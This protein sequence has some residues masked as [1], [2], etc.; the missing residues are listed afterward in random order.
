MFHNHRYIV[1]G[2]VTICGI[3]LFTLISGCRKQAS[4]IPFEYGDVAVADTVLKNK[5]KGLLNIS[6][7]PGDTGVDIASG[8]V[9]SANTL[10]EVTAFKISKIVLRIRSEILAG[11]ITSSDTLVTFTPRFTLDRSSSYT[12]EIAAFV[13]TQGDKELPPVGRAVNEKYTFTTTTANPSYIMSRQSTQVTDFARDGSEL[14]QVGDH[15]YLYGGWTGEGS[16]NDV[17][18]SNGDLSVWDR[19]PDAPWAGRHT[20]GVAKIA[21]GI[22]VFGGDYN[23]SNFDV[24]KTTNGIA[25]EPVATNLETT[26]K[27]RI[28]YGSFQ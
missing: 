15:M 19:M 1:A 22:F 6:P 27:R 7:A 26:V 9:I 4:Q 17:Y 28:I 21:S 11:D 14:M 5:P 8:V 16:F 24:W 25:F 18:R 20:F 3:L 10:R 2:I 12:V 23:N 13:I